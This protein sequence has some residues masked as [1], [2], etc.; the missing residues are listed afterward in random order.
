[1]SLHNE[2]QIIMML[3]HKNKR[4]G[5]IK[6]YIKNSIKDEMLFERQMNEDHI[7]TTIKFLK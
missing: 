5:V 6:D 4:D 3:R 7:L 2:S 1:M